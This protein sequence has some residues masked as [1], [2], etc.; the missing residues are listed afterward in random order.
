MSP[1]AR[2]LA[3]VLGSALAGAV[4]GWILLGPFV[5]WSAG[6]PRGRSIATGLGGLAGLGIGLAV[7]V[8]K[9]RR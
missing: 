2:S 8:F 6:D 7:R 3:I 9:S 4:I 5:G 1:L